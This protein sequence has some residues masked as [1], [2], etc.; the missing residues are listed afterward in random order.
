MGDEVLFRENLV[1]GNKYGG[2]PWLDIIN[3]GFIKGKT[4]KI[5]SPTIL[6]DVNVIIDEKGARWFISDEMIKPFFDIE[7]IKGACKIL[8]YQLEVNSNTPGIH[9]K[10]KDGIEHSVTFDEI[11]KELEDEFSKKKN[12]KL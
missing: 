1:I 7:K 2:L 12:K 5:E 4:Y 8:G 6:D 9:Y 3:S 10:T 11:L